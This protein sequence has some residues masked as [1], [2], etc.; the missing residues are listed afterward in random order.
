MIRHGDGRYV[1]CSCPITLRRAFLA[2]M[3]L[4]VVNTLAADYCTEQ[5]KSCVNITFSAMAAVGSS[6]ISG[7]NPCYWQNARQQTD[8]TKFDLPRETP[9]W[10]NQNSP[11]LNLFTCTVSENEDCAVCPAGV[12]KGTYQPDESC[13]GNTNINNTGYMAVINT[14]GV[15]P[16]DYGKAEANEAADMFNS[17]LTA[18][19]RYDCDSSYV[20]Q[21]AYSAWNCDD[22]RKA[23][24]AWLCSQYLTKCRPIDGNPETCT[25]VKPCMSVCFNVVRKCP[26]SL[27]FQCPDYEGDY[28]D[29]AEDCN[30]MAVARGTAAAHISAAAALSSLLLGL[31]YG[32]GSF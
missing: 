6:N 23:Y 1:T 16:A 31:F 21:K 4:L 10:K 28:L 7:G 3:V 22:C 18:L 26:V 12:N 15:A 17:F 20:A 5:K 24:A 27:N 29:D 11:Y 25:Q 32:G 13:M 30:N 2:A 19:S 8:M 9:I 14:T